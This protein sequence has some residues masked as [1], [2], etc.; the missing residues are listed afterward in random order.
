MTGTDVLLGGVID[1]K[2]VDTAASFEL[3]GTGTPTGTLT[4][5]GSNQYDALTNPSA[6]FVQ[7]AAGAINP[8]LPAI[9]GSVPAYIG[10]LTAQALGCRYIRM[11]YVNSGSTG[12]LNSWFHG[13]GVT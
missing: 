3:A 8:A 13:R 2:D 11:R 5:E 4:L 1:M 10:N 7:L 6:T 9:A 12:V